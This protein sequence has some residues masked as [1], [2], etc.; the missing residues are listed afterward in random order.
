MNTLDINLLLTHYDFIRTGEGYSN[1]TIYMIRYKTD[2][3]IE[4]V[5]VPEAGG[6]VSD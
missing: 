3:T 6:T 4:K 5:T 1:K 2:Y